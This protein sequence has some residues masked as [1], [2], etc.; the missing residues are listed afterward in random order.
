MAGAKEE[1][2]RKAEAWNDK[3]RQRNPP[4]N[5]FRREAEHLF[6]IEANGDF[7]NEVVNDLGLVS[8]LMPSLQAQ[9]FNWLSNKY[10]EAHTDAYVRHEWIKVIKEG[11][12]LGLACMLAYKLSAHKIFYWEAIR[13]LR[14]LNNNG[15]KLSQSSEEFLNMVDA[16]HTSEAVNQ[17]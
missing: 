9:A 4:C 5:A 8:Q 6:G 13:T 7:M 16:Q 2:K 14:I 3:Y 17:V 12:T 15:I 10:A 11:N 1:A